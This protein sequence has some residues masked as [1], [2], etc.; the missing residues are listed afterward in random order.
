MTFNEIETRAKELF[1][2]EHAA[3]L[4]AY[5]DEGDRVYWRKLAIEELEK[6]R[7]DKNTAGDF[8]KL[9]DRRLF[10]LDPDKFDSFANS[11]E[12]PSSPGPALNALM[13]RQPM[14]RK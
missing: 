10:W 8:D 2:E 11:L 14:W 12:N 5:L 1:S 9:A 6:R 7:D 4:W 3:S 13:R